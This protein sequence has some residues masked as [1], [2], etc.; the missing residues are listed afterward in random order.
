MKPTNIFKEIFRLVVRLVGL[1]FLCIG[2]K[3]FFLQTLVALTQLR[4]ASLV[5]II[6]TFLPT[7]FTLAMA[8]WLLRGTWLIRMAY[9]EPER[10]TDPASRQPCPWNRNENRLVQKSL[11]HRNRRRK[12]RGIGR[13]TKEFLILVLATKHSH[14]ASPPNETGPNR[15]N[16]KISPC[17]PFRD[18]RL[19]DAPQPFSLAA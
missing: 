7:C 4:G 15:S 2:M 6:S 16:T 8:V 3:D 12:A 14:F 18:A 5:N 11:G 13:K 17:Q 1:F 19:P 10:S 9:P